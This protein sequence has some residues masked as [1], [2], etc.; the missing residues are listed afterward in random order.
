M[1]LYERLIGE[2]TYPGVTKIPVHLFQALC[3]EYARGQLTAQQA[4][5]AIA[6]KTGEGLTASE[7]AEANTLLATI[8]GTADERARRVLEIDHVLL[9]CDHSVTGYLT[10]AEL[11]TRLGV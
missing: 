5:D 2:I 11:K 8:T 10:E 3:G 9:I 6:D 1:A 4:S 7:L